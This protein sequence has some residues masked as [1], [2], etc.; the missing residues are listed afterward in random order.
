[1]PEV[2]VAGEDHGHAGG[3]GGGDD[4]FVAHRATR[5]D[6]GGSTGVDG[7][8]KPVCEGEHGVGGDDAALEIEAGF[9]GF[10]NGDA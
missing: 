5:L 1:M 3:I 7:G 8:L 4:F 10:P 9:L 6:A 2:P